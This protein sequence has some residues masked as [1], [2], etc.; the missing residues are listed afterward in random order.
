M[1]DM[2]VPV[3]VYLNEREHARLEK[4]SKSRGW[5]KSDAIRAALRAFI[6]AS[7][8]PADSLLAAAGF[9]RGLPPDASVNF[10]RYLNETYRAKKTRKRKSRRPK[11]RVRR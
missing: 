5:T 3:Q 4:L 11:P 8:P 1:Q 10:D 9:I 2:P 7:E 6:Q